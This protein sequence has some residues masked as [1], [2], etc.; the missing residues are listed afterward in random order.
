MVTML[1]SVTA[2]GEAFLAESEEERAVAVE[3]DSHCV[4]LCLSSFSLLRFTYKFFEISRMFPRSLKDMAPNHINRS[5]R[6][7]S[8]RIK[9]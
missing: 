5:T 1:L 7:S 2:Q 4:S 9:L 3:E 8:Q 6:R